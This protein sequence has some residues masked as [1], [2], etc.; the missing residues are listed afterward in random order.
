[1]SAK[2]YP[3]SLLP[4]LERVYCQ[5]R[6]LPD[7]SSL[8]RLESGLGIYMPMDEYKDKT[9]SGQVRQVLTKSQRDTIRTIQF[10]H[11][12]PFSHARS[13]HRH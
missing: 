5:I 1:M 13:R 9:E 8:A 3:Y 2:T 11:V 6:T 4:H 10:P 7:T 12:D